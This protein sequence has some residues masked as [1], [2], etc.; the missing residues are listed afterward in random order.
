MVAIDEQKTHTTSMS[1]EV[2][3]KLVSVLSKHTANTEEDGF[4]VLIPAY[5]QRSVGNAIVDF[6][7]QEWNWEKHT[8]QDVNLD[9]E[10]DDP[11][12]G[13][14]DEQKYIPEH[15]ALS[16]EQV[17][18]LNQLKTELAKMLKDE[19]I[20][21][22][23]LI[24]VDCKFGLGLTK[25]STIGQELTMQECCEVLNIAGETQA[26][27]IARCQVLLD[28]G[29]DMVR[30]RI[31]EHLPS[32]VDVWQS[33][34]NINTA[35]RRE[36]SQ[37]LGLTDNEIE[38]L[39]KARQLCSIDELLEK[40]I[41]KQARFEEIVKSGAVAAFV[42][43]DINS[44]TNRDIQDILG[45]DKNLANAIVAKR[46]FSGASELIKLGL[47]DQSGLN[48]LIQRGLIVKANIGDQGRIDLNQATIEELCAC[49]LSQQVAGLAIKGRPFYTFSELEDFLDTDFVT[50]TLIRQKFRLGIN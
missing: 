34:V 20:A 19:S 22:E 33:D 48:Q 7:R 40:Q 41:V 47:I 15:Q 1:V 50:W 16:G 6:I 45:A 38:R 2:A 4:K 43:L 18:L 12:E 39:L 5:M 9:P 11:R 35:S 3:Q 31:R 13:V 26:R 14:A 30:Q 42:P 44:A 21:Q 46:P 29:L 37:H 32:I 8:L 36:L 28:K 24:V 10:Q 17:Q 23:A 25:N 49:G 27:K